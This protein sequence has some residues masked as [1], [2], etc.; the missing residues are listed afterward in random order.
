MHKLLEN[1][2]DWLYPLLRKIGLGDTLAS[3]ISLLFDIVLLCFI[4]YF[5]YVVFRLTLV[6][7]MAIVAKKPKRI[8]MTCWFPIKQ[9]N[10]L[11]I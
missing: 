1:I 2:F 11:R 6:T 4:A 9:P 7:I 3:Y 8:L 10:T 5:I